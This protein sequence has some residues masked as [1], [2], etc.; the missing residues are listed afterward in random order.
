[1]A[2]WRWPG[3]ANSLWQQALAP[4]D[5]SSFRS[6][7][8]AD[9]R[10]QEPGP[11]AGTG[12]ETTAWPRAALLGNPAHRI[13]RVSRSLNHS[14]LSRC[15]SRL[16]GA[17][18]ALMPGPGSRPSLQPHAT[19]DAPQSPLPW[20]LLQ[21]WWFDAENGRAAARPC[22]STTLGLPRFPH[23]QPVFQAAFF[24]S[25]EQPR[26]RAIPL[27]QGRRQDN[28]EVSLALG[29]DA[30]SSG[31]SE[32]QSLFGN[33]GVS[34]QR[35]FARAGNLASPQALTLGIVVQAS[36]PPAMGEPGWR[37]DELQLL[38][39]H[40]FC[41]YD[42][43]SWPVE[44]DLSRG[45]P[46]PAAHDRQMKGAAGARACDNARVA[47]K[48]SLERGTVCLFSPMLLGIT[49]NLQP[50]GRGDGSGDRPS[51]RAWRPRGKK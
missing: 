23:H 8:A 47:S 42:P 35:A 25:G 17:D 21:A 36:A 19:A 2:N 6:P 7:C 33:A 45:T 27:R 41:A 20:K 49:L 1:V 50:A 22:L 29:R 32:S 46:S 26:I 9:A 39:P 4:A 15:P 48:T 37:P 40:T 18:C 51:K 3:T 13:E 30:I 5:F 28:H 44:G 16:P 12:G 43:G 11:A 10:R 34:A 38:P 14:I 31:S 24:R